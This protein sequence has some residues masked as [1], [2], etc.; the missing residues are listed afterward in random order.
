ML[1]LGFSNDEFGILLYRSEAEQFQEVF[2]P[3]I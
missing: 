1:N 2:E 3:I